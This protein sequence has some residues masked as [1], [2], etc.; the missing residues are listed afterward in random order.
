MR[1]FLDHGIDR[2]RIDI[3]CLPLVESLNFYKCMDIVLD[4]F[5]GSG[6]TAIECENLKRNCQKSL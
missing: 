2:E 5:V 1:K 6:T 3:E 4:P